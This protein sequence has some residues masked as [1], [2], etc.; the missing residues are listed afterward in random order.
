MK[1]V[2]KIKPPA[3]LS[4]FLTINPSTDKSITTHKVHQKLQFS[5]PVCKL[6]CLCFRDWSIEATAMER[7]ELLRC[8]RSLQDLFVSSPPRSLHCSSIE[9]SGSEI[10][11]CQRMG[12]TDISA[13]RLHHRFQFG[14]LRR[15]LLRRPWRPALGAIPE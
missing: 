7:K 2:Q 15:R 8:S 3:I 4:C 12:S 11:T 6:L 9:A 14:N 5:L 13:S 10:E 1:V